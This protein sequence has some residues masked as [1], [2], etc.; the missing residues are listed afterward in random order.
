MALI[1]P[2]ETFKNTFLIRT[3]D[4]AAGILKDQHSLSRNNCHRYI[5]AAAITIIL[6]TVIDQ[7]VDDLAQNRR[8]TLD[9]S[10]T[11]ADTDSDI[12]SGCL[13]LQTLSRIF[14]QFFQL[15]HFQIF[16][17]SGSFVQ[18]R[19]FHNIIDQ[20]NQVPS[21]AVDF[22]QKTL[23]VTFLDQTVFHDLG[24]TQNRLQRRFQFVGNIS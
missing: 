13:S 6:D 19:Q 10:F 21:F 15:D 22:F 18:A 4:T 2:I 24:V 23:L 20:A 9:L 16:H 12:F 5:D 11:A 7:I 14:S 1:D 17:I 3:A 8:Y